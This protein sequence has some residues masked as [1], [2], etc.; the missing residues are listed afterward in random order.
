MSFPIYNF[1]IKRLFTEF[2]LFL[3]NE[4]TL[5]ICRRLDEIGDMTSFWWIPM[6]K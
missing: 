4:R 6:A 3:V 5:P 1:T 2:I